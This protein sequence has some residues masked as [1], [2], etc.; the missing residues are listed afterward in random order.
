VGRNLREIRKR[1]QR[2]AR[3]QSQTLVVAQCAEIRREAMEAFRRS[4]GTHEVVTTRQKDGCPDTVTTRTEEKPGNAAF[5]N[6]A[7]RAAT[8][9][10]DLAAQ[11]PA[12]DG[13]K[14]GAQGAPRASNLPSTPQESTDAARLA[15]M[16][17]LTPE[18]SSVLSPEQRR[19]F[20]VAFQRWQELF[21]V[22]NEATRVDAEP[23]TAADTVAP[24]ESANERTAGTVNSIADG[25]GG[26]SCH[27]DLAAGP[28]T[29]QP[30]ARDG[31]EESSQVA[32]VEATTSSSASRDASHD[33]G[34]SQPSGD[35]PTVRRLAAMRHPEWPAESFLSR[36]W[37]PPDRSYIPDSRENAAFDADFQ[38]RESRVQ[39]EVPA[40]AET[41]A[42]VG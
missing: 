16:E 18:Q 37:L 11:L 25:P 9:L 24:L 31:A 41:P 3:R 27:A 21:V 36:S 7:L 35:R 40:E 20:A 26:P 6:A 13:G 34:P 5:L 14:A 17:V 10:S 4:Q 2:A 32:A 38:A 28:E 29:A 12:T 39:S 42:N 33:A 1:H 19:D 30:R 15:L 8:T 22:I 23:R